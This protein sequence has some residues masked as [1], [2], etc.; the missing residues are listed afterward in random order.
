MISSAMTSGLVS[1]DWGALIVRLIL[2]GFFILARF[3]FFWDPS[4][5]EHCFLNPIRHAS[6]TAKMCHCGVKGNPLFWAWFT[7]IVEVFGGLSV[8]TGLLTYLGALGLI[9]ITIRGTMCTAKAKVMEQKPVDLVDCV[10][11]YL[12]RV[13]GIYIAMAALVFILG[14]GKYSLDSLIWSH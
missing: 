12:W 10:S 13:E 9:A 4:N 11:C 6:L 8:A 3:R 2:G 7:A 1:H 14:P 5:P